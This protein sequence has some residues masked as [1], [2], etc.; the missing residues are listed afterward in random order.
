MILTRSDHVEADAASEAIA[1]EPFTNAP[2]ELPIDWRNG[3]SSIRGRQSTVANRQ[4]GLDE[5]AGQIG[6]CVFAALGI[7]TA[8]FEQYRTKRLAACPGRRVFDDHYVYTPEDMEHILQEGPE[9]RG[10]E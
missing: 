7:R 5:L 3:A 10:R 8:F 4:I 2:P 6:V 1:A 9:K